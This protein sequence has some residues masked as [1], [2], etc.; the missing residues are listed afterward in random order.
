[1]EIDEPMN[2]VTTPVPVQVTAPRLTQVEQHILDRLTELTHEVVNLKD[3]TKAA[4]AA[5]QSAAEPTAAHS[6]TGV[7]DSHTPNTGGDAPPRAERQYLPKIDLFEGDKPEKAAAFL[8]LLEL[9]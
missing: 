1:M 4:A 5:K 8:N 7:G 2:P 6:A 3:E 9:R